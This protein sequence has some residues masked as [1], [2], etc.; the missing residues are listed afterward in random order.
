MAVSGMDC[1]LKC[2]VAHN[3]DIIWELFRNVEPQ[4]HL[5]P[6]SPNLHLKEIS[7]YL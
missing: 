5:S 3:S 7:R 2:N 4:P 6:L 1:Y